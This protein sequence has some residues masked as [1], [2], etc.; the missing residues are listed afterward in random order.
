MVVRN[1][2]S[3]RH[4]SPCSALYLTTLG[5]IYA[6]YGNCTGYY[7]SP[8]APRPFWSVEWIWPQ[9][10]FHSDLIRPLM[11]LCSAGRGENNK[12]TITTLRQQAWSRD[13]KYAAWEAQRTNLGF[14]DLVLL[15]IFCPSSLYKALNLTT[16]KGHQHI[17]S[18]PV[19]NEPQY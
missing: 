4:I 1:L 19:I 11:I 13:T 10:P 7:W 2:D 14:I 8:G 17:L 18:I 5:T 12:A 16:F 6:W 15:T 9:N 3:G